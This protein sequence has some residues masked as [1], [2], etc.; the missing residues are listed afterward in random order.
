MKALSVIMPVY[1]GADYI[2]RSLM[3][4]EHL[5]DIDYECL[6]IDDGSIDGSASI[7]AAMS[8]ENP[9]IILAKRPNGGVSR[10][11]NKGLD[12]AK[13]RFIM[14]LDADDVLLPGA[15]YLIKPIVE[16][17]LLDL[18]AFTYYNW[19]QD[20]S[21]KLES[22]NMTL[23]ER[24]DL[25]S[26]H[27]RLL[28]SSQLNTCWGKLFRKSLID[29]HDMKFNREMKI[30]EDYIFVADYLQYAKSVKL[31]E[32]TLL[33]YRIHEASAMRREELDSRLW[34]MERLYEYDLN[35]MKTM[36]YE[37]WRSNLDVYYFRLIT[38]LIRQATKYMAYKEMVLKVVSHPF[39]LTIITKVEVRKL[40]TLKRLEYYLI[41]LPIK[42]W[43]IQYF[44]LKG[45][46]SA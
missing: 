37:G 30:G 8:R 29:L 40:S 38:D 13:G 25:M 42:G 26:I 15:D 11:R 21:R 7:V 41:H 20:D 12:L 14:F 27:Q 39:V 3:S 33:L 5:G 31:I 17:G 24:E 22:H 44:K 35:W 6:V 34:H 9:R 1:N 46:L 16:E 18:A 2:A 23:E 19:W 36:K 43:M 10:A 28:T 32:E 4:L 45:K